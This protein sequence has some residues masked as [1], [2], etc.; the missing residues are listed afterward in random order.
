MNE[1]IP[2][3]LAIELETPAIINGV[4]LDGLLGGILYETRSSEDWAD[5]LNDLP[6]KRTV[7]EGGARPLYHASRVQILPDFKL[8]EV[9]VGNRVFLNSLYAEDLQPGKRG[10]PKV[11]AARGPYKNAM[12]NYVA[13]SVS[14][15]YFFGVGDPERVC[16]IISRAPSIGARRHS[17]FG[18]I[19]RNSDGSQ[20]VSWAEV[21]GVDVD[22]FGLVDKDGS[23]A[24]PIP[25]STWQS[26]SNAQPA[27]HIETWHN[28]YHDRSLA[29]LCV[30]PKTGWHVADPENEY[31]G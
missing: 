23:P 31:L 30:V 20:A 2:F 13:T 8:S 12:S 9:M 28:P 24:R 10:L 19:A 6:L 15:L 22:R 17:G 26:L 7:I 16:A 14:T 21:E 4:T 11:D 5:S 3:L 18:M 27:I 1:M 25:V 29:T